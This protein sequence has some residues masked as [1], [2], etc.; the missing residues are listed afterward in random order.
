MPISIDT[1]RV[2]KR[3]RLVNFEETHEFDIV[4]AVDKNDFLCKDVMS[5]EYYKLSELTA[6]GRGKDYDF[7]GLND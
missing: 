5:L 1:V 2:G 3:Y 7:Y 6:Y 4:K